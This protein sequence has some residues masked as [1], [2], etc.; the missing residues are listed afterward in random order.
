M[1]VPAGVDWAGEWRQ[2][3]TVGAGPFLPRMRPRQR[4][5]QSSQVDDEHIYKLSLSESVWYRQIMWMI[6]DRGKRWPV[7]CCLLR[8]GLI[9]ATA[10]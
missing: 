5:Q 9:A 3:A 1:K 4:C 10:G 6:L 8:C 7:L 2:A